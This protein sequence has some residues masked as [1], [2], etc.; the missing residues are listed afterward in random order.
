MRK[1]TTQLNMEAVIAALRAAGFEDDGRTE[2]REVR[3]PTTRNPVY[4]GIGG[5]VATFG[6]RLRFRHPAG[7]RATVGKKSTCVY[8][9]LPRELQTPRERNRVIWIGRTGDLTGLAMAMAVVAK[10]AA[11]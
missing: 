3:I 4:G 1:T 5:E 10:D 7:T 11:L 9:V 2:T 8:Q 6:G